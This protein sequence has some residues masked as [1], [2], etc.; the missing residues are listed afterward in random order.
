M[1]SLSMVKFRSF[2][3]LCYNLKDENPL[4]FIPFSDFYWEENLSQLFNDM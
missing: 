2:G 4:S 1:S 3:T